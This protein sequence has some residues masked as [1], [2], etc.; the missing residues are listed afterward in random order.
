MVSKLLHPLSF[1]GMKR[2]P[3]GVQKWALNGSSAPPQRGEAACPILWFYIIRM[4]G[5]SRGL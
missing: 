3:L 5:L 4:T 2:T 1:D